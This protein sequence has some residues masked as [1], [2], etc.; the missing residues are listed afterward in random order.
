MAKRALITGILGQDGAY[1][2][3]HLLEQGYE[4]V[5]GFR[6]NASLDTW[7]MDT[8]GV[9]DEVCFLPLDLLEITNIARVIEKV[10]PDEL[11][12]LAAQSF[13]SA[14]FEQPILTT[15]VDALG[16]ARILECLRSAQHECRFY[17]A[18]S[19]EMFGKAQ[20]IPQSETTPF[21][22]RSPYRGLRP[23]HLLGHLVQSRIAAARGGV[24]HAQDHDRAVPNSP[25]PGRATQAR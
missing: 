17:Q 25:R 3:R 19:S 23:A 6:R 5:G 18:S 13:V 9:S 10:R 8:L 16:T 1:L 11:Y 2:A 22:P 4:V 7:R 15:E 24:R 12:N 14:S 21:Y 20:K